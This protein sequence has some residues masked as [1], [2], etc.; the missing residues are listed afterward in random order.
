MKAIARISV[1][2]IL[3]DGP[4]KLPELLALGNLPQRQRPGT[5]YPAG[6]RCSILQLQPRPDQIRGLSATCTIPD[7]DQ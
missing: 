4:A 2:L 7:Y 6:K 3:P 1:S 5:D